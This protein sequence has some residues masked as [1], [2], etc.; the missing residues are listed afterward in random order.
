MNEVTEAHFDWIQSR[1]G[2]M[3]FEDT[4][5]AFSNLHRA[6]SGHVYFSL[7]DEVGQV[8]AV[9][10]RSAAR[11]IPFELEE[12]AEVVVY[13]DVSIY[14]QRGDLQLIIRQVEP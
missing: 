14:A 13:A 9:M 7:K 3:F 10:F 1:L 12:G 8:R 5:A 2:V 4:A 11:R 6:G